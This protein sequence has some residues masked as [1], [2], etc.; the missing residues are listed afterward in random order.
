MAARVI[1]MQDAE[2]CELCGYR[3]DGTF[4]DRMR[5][6]KSEHPAYA[7]GL[8]FRVAAPGLFLIVVLIL[9]AVHAPAWTFLGAMVAS[10]I[11]LFFGKQRSRGERRHAGASPTLPLKRLMKEG[12]LGFILIIPVIALLILMLSRR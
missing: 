11:L 4:R 8:L 9:A 10:F 7:R 12:G 3:S 5:H 2:R 1:Q 6:L